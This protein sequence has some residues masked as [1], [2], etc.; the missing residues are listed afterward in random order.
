E[1]GK[2]EVLVDERK[3]RGRRPDPDACGLRAVTAAV[4][5]HSRAK[6]RLV[7]NIEQHDVANEIGRAN[8]RQLRPPL[9]RLAR[10]LDDTRVEMDLRQRP[11]RDVDECTGRR[12]QRS[13]IG[14]QWDL[15]SARRQMDERRTRRDEKLA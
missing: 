12:D 9:V 5:T 13:M 14:G 4:D 15:M 11:P 6:S 10:R 2:S 7:R 1:T 3:V 8:E